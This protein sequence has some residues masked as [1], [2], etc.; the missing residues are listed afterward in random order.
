[1]GAVPIEDVYIQLCDFA[2]ERGVE[3]LVL[4]GSRARGSSLSNSDI[5]L[6]V[7]GDDIVGFTED[8]EDRLWSLLKVDVTDLSNGVSNELMK[9]ISRDGRV[10]YEAF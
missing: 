8:V 4:F 2:R 3:R 7:F 1:M 6:A 5:D 9:E 10:L